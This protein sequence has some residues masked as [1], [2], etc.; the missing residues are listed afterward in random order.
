MNLKSLLAV[1][2]SA[3]L[4]GRLIPSFKDAVQSHLTMRQVCFYFGFKIVELRVVF[5]YTH[6]SLMPNT[7]KRPRERLKRYICSYKRI[8]MKIFP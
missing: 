4:F 2:H 8:W 1:S 6:V 3:L 5:K 7:R